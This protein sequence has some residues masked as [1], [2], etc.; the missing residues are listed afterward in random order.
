[1]KNSNSLINVTNI[2]RDFLQNEAKTLEISRGKMLRD[3]DLERDMHKYL[4]VG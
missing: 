2:V 4:K 1:M 3:E